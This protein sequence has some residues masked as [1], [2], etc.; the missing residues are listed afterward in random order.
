MRIDRCGTG[1]PSES[2]SGVLLDAYERYVPESRRAILS[3]SYQAGPDRLHVDWNVTLSHAK[4]EAQF[5]LLV[6]VQT[7][8]LESYPK[9]TIRSSQ[10][11]SRQWG[12]EASSSAGEPVRVSLLGA[13][14]LG[15]TEP[16]VTTP[17][18][19]RPLAGGRWDATVW[20]PAE[21]P[22]WTCAEIP[23]GGDF[24]SIGAEGPGSRQPTGWI[25][26]GNFFEKGVIRCLRLR[27]IVRHGSFRPDDPTDLAWLQ[28]RRADLLHQPL[29]LTT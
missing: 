19:A 7:E 24:V 16:P 17:P 23:F 25:F 21:A 3:A 26:E 6:A 9:V 5:D 20:V 18:A 13:S 22:Q 29:P 28:E 12:V 10:A 8:L 4:Q 15:A 14:D 27:A 2:T 1:E 11:C